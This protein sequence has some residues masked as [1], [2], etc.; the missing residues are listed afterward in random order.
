MLVVLPRGLRAW[1]IFSW[2]TLMVCGFTTCVVAVLRWFHHA[3]IRSG[4]DKKILRY[5]FRG[6]GEEPRCL[7]LGFR[8]SLCIWSGQCACVLQGE[9]LLLEG[10]SPLFPHAIVCENKRNPPYLVTFIL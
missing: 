10:D 2:V 9:V 7:V 1:S 5:I 3:F 8:G 6:V 4:W